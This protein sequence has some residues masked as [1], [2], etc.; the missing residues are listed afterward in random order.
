[1]EWCIFF[2]EEQDYFIHHVGTTSPQQNTDPAIAASFK[3][4]VLHTYNYL[5]TDWMD[6][7]LDDKGADTI[8]TVAVGS[9]G[10]FISGGRRLK[11]WAKT[12][13]TETDSRLKE[14]GQAAFLISIQRLPQM[15]PSPLHTC[16]LVTLQEFRQF[17]SP[18][19]WWWK[20]YFFLPL[21]ANL[22]TSDRY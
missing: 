20:G 8:L 1:M 4:T 14:A 19:Q 18:S 10:I 17:F 22:G 13:S 6:M 21:P 9:T 15:S 16:F 5:R 11:A 7:I 3:G 2:A 12:M